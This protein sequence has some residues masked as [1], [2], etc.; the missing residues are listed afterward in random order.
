VV[1]AL[2]D[3]PLI[4]RAATALSPRPEGTPRPGHTLG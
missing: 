4:G 3:H 1:W 2:H